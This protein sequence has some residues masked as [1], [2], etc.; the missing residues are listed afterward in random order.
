MTWKATK[1]CT[2]W[3]RNRDFL[4]AFGFE[5][6]STVGDCSC[7]PSTKSI[8][9]GFCNF[10]TMQWNTTAPLTHEPLQE[11][12][13]RESSKVGR[14]E[15]GLSSNRPELVTLIEFLEVHDDHTDLLYLTDSEATL[16]GIHKW[17]GGGSK[18][19]LSESP[20]ADVLKV[21]ILKLHKRVEAGATTL[22]IKVKAHR[23]DPLKEQ[24]CT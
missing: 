21:I 19:N 22:L 7:D 11:Q 12:R 13:F 23:G 5:G 24:Y 17:K 15:E 18:L 8:G 16:K 3:A 20:D 1:N 2:D 6:A 4:G 14:E 10:V 9:P